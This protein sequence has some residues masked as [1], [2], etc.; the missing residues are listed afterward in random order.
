MTEVAVACC[1]LGPLMGELEHN[2]VQARAAIEAAARDGAK[3]IVLPELCNSGYVFA[4]ADE[5][6]RLAEPIDGATR[7]GWAELP[8]ALRPV[9]AGGFCEVDPGG[10]VR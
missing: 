5:A 6:R 4:D 9:L 1:Q 2:R 10:R 3:V 8:P 7:T